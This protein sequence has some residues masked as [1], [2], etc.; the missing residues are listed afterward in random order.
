MRK[1][2]SIVVSGALVWG[3][4]V[5]A[6]SPARAILRFH[7]EA[8]RTAHA[9]GPHSARQIPS[10]TPPAYSPLIRSEQLLHENEQE[11][12]VAT[13]VDLSAPLRFAP[14]SI[15]MTSVK[16]S[17]GASGSVLSDHD[18]SSGS[19]IAEPSSASNGSSILQTWNWGAATSSNGGSSWLYFD[20]YTLFPSSYGGF[21][22]DQQTYYEPSRDLYIWV[23]QYVPDAAKNNALR[24]AVANGSSNLAAGRF[25]YWDVTPQQVGAPSGTNYDQPKLTVTSN[26]LYIEASKYDGESG[27]VVMRIPLDVLKSHGQLN[28]SYWNTLFSPGFAQGGTSTVW[29]A[30]HYSTAV[31]T[32]YHIDESSSTL[33]SNDVPHALYP[34]S[35]PYTCPRSGSSSDWCQRRSFGSGGGYAHDDRIHAGWLANGV[36]GFAWDASQGVGGLG[37]FA[38][39]YE[40]IVRID[41]TLLLLIDAPGSNT[42]GLAAS[43]FASNPQ[44]PLID[45]PIIYNSAYAYSYFSIAPNARGDLAGVYMYGG[46]TQYEN[47]GG[48]LHDSV[49]ASEGANWDL[50]GIASS[51]VDP[52][53]NLSGD[54]LSAR[55]SAPGAN[56]WS[57]SCYALQTSS[58]STHVHYLKL[59]R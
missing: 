7:T 31:L 35:L 58:S 41:S 2:G 36:L 49:T 45:Q 12:S 24:I 54:Y 15:P 28:Y 22:C 13:P 20:P 3:S 40:H 34:S 9:F 48:L 56:T 17:S 53:D 42:A 55:I 33:V 43:Y 47:C 10:L 37:T 18:L 23:L 19:L 21:C 8:G 29:F 46:G 57:A 51:T 59:G 38:F 27:S 26:Y 1:I 11:S 44:A 30:A 6:A 50:F 32:V 4:L 39:P 5:L 14:P 25:S 16:T 52:N